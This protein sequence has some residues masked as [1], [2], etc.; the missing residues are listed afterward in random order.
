MFTVQ[1]NSTRGGKSL[2]AAFSPTLFYFSF[3]L[4]CFTR[5]IVYIVFDMRINYAKT[6][7]KQFQFGLGSTPKQFKSCFSV[8][9]QFRFRRACQRLQ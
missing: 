6:I 9:I 1:S 4:D 8:L 5:A 7:M 3:V 2:T